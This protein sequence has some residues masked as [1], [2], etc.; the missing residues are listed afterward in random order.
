MAHMNEEMLRATRQFDEVRITSPQGEVTGRIVFKTVLAFEGGN[1]R[2]GQ[3]RALRALSDMAREVAPGLAY[4]QCAG[5]DARPE[6]FDLATFRSRSAAAIENLHA[7][8]PYQDGIDLGL[9]GAPFDPSTHTGISAFGGSVVAGGGLEGTADISILEFS[10]SLGWDAE[11]MFRRQIQRTIAAASTLRAQF[12]LAGFGIQ[13]DQI[14]PSTAGDFPYL[15]RFPGIHCSLDD[16]FA[17]EC[18][19]RRKTADRY[20]S[21]NWLTLIGHQMLS[22]LQSANSEELAARVGGDC[23]VL[24]YDG[25]LLIRAGDYPQPGDVNQGIL[26]EGYRRVS[27]A[28]LRLRFE[29]Y[30][31]P[32]IAAPLPLNSLEETLAWIRRFD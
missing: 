2:D 23:A 11:S 12:G 1:T 17:A 30:K 24:P 19:V 25:G 21:I 22:E 31:V 29:G 3:L 27:E 13:R 4:M 26:L 28:T 10:T 6:P 20:F 15:K 7:D 16:G 8:G 5:P 18:A 14:Y 32:V 9:F